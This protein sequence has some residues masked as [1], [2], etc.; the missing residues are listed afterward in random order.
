MVFIDTS[1]FKANNYFSATSKINKLAELASKGRISIVLTSITKAEIIKHL[2]RDIENARKSVRKKDNEVLRNIKGTDEYFSALDNLN[3]EETANEMV[4][5]FINRSGAYVIGL[6]YCKDIDGIFKKYFMQ[7][8][9][10]SEKKQKEFPDAFALATLEGY[11]RSSQ[12]KIIVLSTDPDMQ[13]YKS[14][15]LIVEDYKKY[16]TKVSQ[17]MAHLH[18][19]T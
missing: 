12:Y 16:V 18:N 15:E 11:N 19:L 8:F 5:A 13:N 1:V 10:F 4:K 7:E 2:M 9:P 6:E 3:A 14:D 17:V